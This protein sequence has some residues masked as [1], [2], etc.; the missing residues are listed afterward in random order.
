M[1]IVVIN[2]P[3]LGR[4]GRREPSVYGRT[5]L[6]EIEAMLRAAA[7]RLD[8]ELEF[9]QSDIEGE[10]VRRIGEAADEADGMIVNPA[11]YTHTS[12]ALRDAIAGSGL[13]CV[14]VHLTNTT[15]REPFRHS[16]L[17]APVCVG[18]IM[19]FGPEGYRLALWGL[20]ARAKES[21]RRRST[22]RARRSS[23]ERKN[24]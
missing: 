1:K 10:L 12:V 11:A 7:A 3:N 24:A 4:L 19:G 17:T 13:P 9:F 8:V 23:S 18:Q 22:A 5:T 6:A 20:V 2:G 21:G 16:S 14:E 15:A